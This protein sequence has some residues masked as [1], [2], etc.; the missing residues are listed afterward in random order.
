MV[1]AAGSPRARALAAALRKAR[2]E[3]GLSLRA[4]AHRLKL[5]QSYLSRIENGKRVP[6]VETT[7]RI[8]GTLQSSP[9][10]FE[11]IERFALRVRKGSPIRAKSKENKN[12]L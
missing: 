3:T 11:R 8:L 4:L 6:S 9:D 10:E 5:D 2:E 1:S 12:L 7:A